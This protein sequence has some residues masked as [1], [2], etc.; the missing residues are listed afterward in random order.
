[1]PTYLEL[2][3]SKTPIPALDGV[4]LVAEMRSPA[5]VPL[6]ARDVI[7]DLPED[8]YNERRR[9]LVHGTTKL[10]SF[11]ND[12]RYSMFDLEADPHE[13]D[14]LFRKKPELAAE[15]KRLYKEG[16]KRIIES[17]PRGGIP[18]HTR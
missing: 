1:M 4:S 2:L 13:A 5:S 11:G 9:A 17:P 16:S 14:D 10:I 8:E 6:A 7:V 18:S 12:V 15:M 3:G